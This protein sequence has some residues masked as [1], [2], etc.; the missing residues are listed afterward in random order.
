[1]FQKYNYSCMSNFFFLLGV[2]VSCLPCDITALQKKK[3]TPFQDIV[4]L[5]KHYFPI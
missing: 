2:Q 3:T 5:I 1:M 4:A